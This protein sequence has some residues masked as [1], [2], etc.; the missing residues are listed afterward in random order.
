[1][2]FNDQQNK[3]IANYV[4]DEL[5]LNPITDNV[6][7][8]VV[9]SI[10]P[11]FEVNRKFV[12]IQRATPATANSNSTIL[13][14][15][16]SVDTFITAA[17][18]YFIKDAT[19]DAASGVGPQITAQLDGDSAARAIVSTAIITLTAQEGSQTQSFNPPLKIARGSTI[20]GDR[21]AT[22]SAGNLVRSYTIQGFTEQTGDVTA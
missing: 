8:T 10:Q 14:T 2:G 18:I 11:T 4:I 1:M 15:S 16:S 7:K 12:N 19:C 5:R 3:R 22:F 6:P 13:T 17:S 21:G 20:T 9:P